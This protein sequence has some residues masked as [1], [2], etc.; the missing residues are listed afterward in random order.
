MTPVHL[1]D[2]VQHHSQRRQHV[3]AFILQHWA[4][5]LGG[6]IFLLVCI[7]A[8]FAPVISPYDPALQNIPSRLQGPSLVHL[9]GTDDFGRDT[10]SRIVWG[11]QPILIAGVTSVLLS[12]VLG[13]MLGLVAGY[14]GG[15]VDNLTMRVIDVIL[16]FP[17]MLLA[18]LIVATLGPGLT[19]AIIAIAFAQ[20]PMFARLVRALVLS[21]S[22]NDYIEAARALGIRQIRIMWRH[23]VPNLLGPVIVQATAA[24]ALAIGYSTAL[25]FLGLGV[26]PPAA[27]WGVMINDGRRLIF[28][29]PLVPFIPGAAITFTVL[30]LNF[31]G[32][33]LRD[34]LD[35]AA[36]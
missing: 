22:E 29:N 27:D 26:Q 34:W 11:A 14:V 3:R 33:G 8:L 9:L 18:I 30:G 17:I 1:R 31:L 35:P 32:D 28:S 24:L 15:W 16:S 36:R 7:A 10:F 2:D 25:S 20:I 23:I 13:A 5:L 6:A 21:I 4:A 19:N 12:M